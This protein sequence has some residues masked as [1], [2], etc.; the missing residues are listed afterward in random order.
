MALA[1]S[2]ALYAIGYVL[3]RYIDPASGAGMFTAQ[4]MFFSW[5]TLF[6]FAKSPSLRKPTFAG[7]AAMA[8]NGVAGPFTVYLIMLG[9]M[10]VTP[11]LSSLIV[12]S[13]VLFIAL[14]ARALGRKR[15]V[16]AQAP[17]LAVGF[18]GVAYI[19]AAHGAL[20]GDPRGTLFLTLASLMIAASTIVIER[21]LA[22]VGWAPVSRWVSAISAVT[23]V[24]A[25][26]I[27]GGLHFHSPSQTGLAI[28]MGVFSLGA[29][30]ILYSR[31]M[32]ILGSADTAVF[33]LLIPFFSLLYGAAIFRE[34]PDPGSF[35]AGLLVAGA[36]MAYHYSGHVRAET[37]PDEKLGAQEEG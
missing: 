15:F 6:L 8:F 26:A 14:I 20:Y 4:A 35:A 32:S 31:G 16:G 19:S 1:V 25:I 2:S 28:I 37:V 23:A 11:A 36:L 27:Q 22:E 7:W 30:G 12:I 33:K 29:P 17:A 5:L 34:I 9:S 21:P 18:A 13:N 3:A 10:S 24:L